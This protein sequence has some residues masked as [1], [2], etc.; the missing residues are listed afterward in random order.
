LPGTVLLYDFAGVANETMVYGLALFCFAALILSLVAARTAE[1][2]A[3]ERC[4]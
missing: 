1:Q 3:A 4:G 2:L